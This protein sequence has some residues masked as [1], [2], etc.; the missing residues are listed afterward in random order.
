MRKFIIW[1]VAAAS[2][3]CALVLLA[4]RWEPAEGRDFKPWGQCT[5]RHASCVERCML[6]VCPSCEF[7]PCIQRTCDKQYDNCIKS[8]G[9]RPQSGGGVK[10]TGGGVATQPKSSTKGTGTPSL[11]NKWHG[12]TSVPKSSGAWNQSQGSG[13]TGPILKSGG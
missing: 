8:L 2:L 13:G 4:S 6:R 5:T 3:A 10:D 7:T 12:P 1:T 11:D 9:N